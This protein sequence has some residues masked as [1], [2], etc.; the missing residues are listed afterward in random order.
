MT[1]LSLPTKRLAWPG[2]LLVDARLDAEHE[3]AGSLEPRDLAHPDDQDRVAEARDDGEEDRLGQDGI[4]PDVERGGGEDSKRGRP[5]AE[6]RLLHVERGQDLASDR[7][8]LL[9]GRR[10][11]RVGSAT[12]HAR[13]RDLAP[14][15]DHGPSLLRRQRR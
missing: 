4:V 2:K 1:K 5:E 10:E 9:D 14:V 8:V 12:D 3:S 6:R 7:P 11:P 13:R 15:L